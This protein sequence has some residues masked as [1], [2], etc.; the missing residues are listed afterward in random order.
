[1]S[2]NYLGLLWFLS[3]YAAVTTSAAEA[4]R[5]YS[6]FMLFPSILG[7]VQENIQFSQDMLIP[8]Y[9]KHS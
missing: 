9:S 4:N 1:M 8:Q 5:D 2:M 6:E 7:L 3:N